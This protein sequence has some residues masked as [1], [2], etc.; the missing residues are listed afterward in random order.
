MVDNHDYHDDGIETDPSDM[1]AVHNPEHKNMYQ[2][3]QNHQHLH[4]HH[5][6]GTITTKIKRNIKSFDNTA[7]SSITACH[8]I[9]IFVG[10]AA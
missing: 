1:G 9:T 3:E 2:Q 10:L 6:F 4:L 8:Q 7:L 5:S